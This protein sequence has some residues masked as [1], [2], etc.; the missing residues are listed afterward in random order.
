MSSLR[1]AAIECGLPNAEAA[2][3]AGLTYVK[4]LGSLFHVM[5]SHVE[6]VQTVD[7]PLLVR[8]VSQVTPNN[9]LVQGPFAF[10]A[11]HHQLTDPF[12]LPASPTQMRCWVSSLF[13]HR[14]HHPPY[15]NPR[16]GM[17]A[18][19]VSSLFSLLMRGG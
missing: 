16:P 4:N 1:A 11:A 2:L 5:L 13:T 12:A 8:H 7:L 10:S 18:Y 3:A 9:Q 19:I 17:Q 14:R 15:I 6:A